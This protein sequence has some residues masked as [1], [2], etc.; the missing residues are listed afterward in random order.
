MKGG[1]SFGKGNLSDLVSSVSSVL[2][3]VS[4]ALASK[5][6]CDNLVLKGRLRKRA[7]VKAH[8]YR[9]IAQDKNGTL[10]AFVSLWIQVA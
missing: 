2:N 8:G 3:I 4:G 10:D 6:H 1:S 7:E 9:H 5:S